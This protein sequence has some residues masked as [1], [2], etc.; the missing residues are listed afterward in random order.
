MMKSL[1]KFFGIAAIL[2]TAAQF[3]SA[4]TVKIEKP[5]DWTSVYVYSWG[6]AGEVFGGWPGQE[7]TETEGWYAAMLDETVLEANIIFNNNDGVQTENQFVSADVCFEW[8]GELNA[9]N[10]LILTT[11]PCND[12]GI[13]IGF[14]KPASWTEVY[15]YGYVND[16][17]V[18]GNWPGVMLTSENDWYYYTMDASLSEVNVIY[19]N[20]A[21]EQTTDVL[22]VEDIC[23]QAQEDLSMLE[24]E[25][26]SS[27][28]GDDFAN[29][30]QLTFYPNPAN[31]VLNIRTAEDVKTLSINTIT[32]AKVLEISNQAEM[33]SINISSLNAGVYFISFTLTDGSKVTGK[34]IKN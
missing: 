25:C 30:N 23:Y 16:A 9:S 11:V 3:A 15:I 1:L 14:Q 19:T 4:I 12:A 18:F 17:P 27:S 5:G 22:V 10:E 2:F 29:N 24:V 20:N 6:D 13:K 8:T 32:G 31:E 28:I 26:E 21:G 34:F 7:L 33:S